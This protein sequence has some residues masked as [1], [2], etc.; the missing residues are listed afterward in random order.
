MGQKEVRHMHRHA[1][2][3]L[4][5]KGETLTKQNERKYNVC[6][7]GNKDPI[8]LPAVCQLHQIS[9]QLLSPSTVHKLHYIKTFFF[10]K[11]CSRFVSLQH[12]TVKRRSKALY[13]LSE[14]NQNQNQNPS[15]LIY[16]HQLVKQLLDL[17]K[18]VIQVTICS[19]TLIV[20]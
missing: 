10:N 1:K 15:S 18:D 17:T 12:C 20:E 16:S 4:C 8:L 3:S 6:K 14:Q 7:R 9:S 5:H 2:Q 19:I 11:C 13:M